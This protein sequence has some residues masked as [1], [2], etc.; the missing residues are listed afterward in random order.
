MKTAIIITLGLLAIFV[1]VQAYVSRS[2]EKTEQQEYEVIESDGDFEIRFYP[3]A[4]LASVEVDGNY[5][6]SSGTGF[7][8]LAGYI[9][10]SNETGEK[11]AMTSPVHMQESGE[12][13]FM[14][15]VMPSGYDSTNLPV[16]DNGQIR[17]HRSAPVHTASLRF[18]GYASDEKIE[19]YKQKLKD[20]L[21]EKD[22]EPDGPF[23]YLGYNP[24]YQMVNR[25]NEIMVTVRR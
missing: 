25:R 22:I 2:T 16:P 21:E 18:G 9:F 14:S 17:I 5:R 19:E 1:F 15:F 7:R 3:S 4:T 23:V 12:G 20:I 6:S 8:I 11:I 24:P 13:Y 10:G